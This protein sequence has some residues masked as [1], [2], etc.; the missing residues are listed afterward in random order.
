MSKHMQIFEAE[1]SLRFCEN[2]VNC[3]CESP[4][5][6]PTGAP[7]PR[8]FPVNVIPVH[9]CTCWLLR[10]P[11]EQLGPGKTDFWGNGLLLPAGKN[12]FQLQNKYHLLH[13][14]CSF[15]LTNCVCWKRL[16]LNTKN[17]TE[18]HFFFYLGRSAF[19][20]VIHKWIWNTQLVLSLQ[21]CYS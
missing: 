9:D 3:C 21:K 18:L 12:H 17:S 15:L 5:S 11:W 19:H 4:Q 10:V 8:P 14:S 2:V 16:D 7:P 1:N 13:F 20:I 6:H